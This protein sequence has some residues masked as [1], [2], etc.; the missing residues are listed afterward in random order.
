M[1]RPLHLSWSIQSSKLFSMKL[2]RLFFLFLLLTG[3]VSITGASTRNEFTLNNNWKFIKGNDVALL[4][5]Q[6]ELVNIPHTW[7][8]E[9]VMDDTPGYYRGMGLYK[10]E[11]RIPADWKE[12][13]VYLYFEG[14]AQVTEL[15]VN[16]ISAGKHIGSYTAFSFHLNKYLQFSA[17]G[18]QANEIIVKVDNSHNEDIPPL[19]G[20]FTLF[21]G[22]YR[23][24][25]I[26]VLPKVH[27]DADNYASSGVFI[28]TP[29]VT[30]DKAEVLIK[31]AF[32]N[33]TNKKLTVEVKHDILDTSGRLLTQLKQ[34]YKVAAGEKLAFETRKPDITG[35]SLWSID[36]PY[37]Y[38]VVSTI[39]DTKNEEVLDKISNPLGFR[40]FEF[41]PDKGFLL[42]GKHLKLIGASRHQDFKGLG[43]ALPNTLHVRDVELLKEMGGNFLRIAHYPQ[44]PEVLQACDRLGVL[45]TIETPIVNRITETED[46]T[47]N[48]TTMHLEM[49][50]QSYNHPS[51]IVWAYMNE[52]LLRPRFDKGSDRQEIYFK[53]ITRLARQLDELTRRED[54]YRYTMISNH[55]N[56]SLYKRLELTAIPQLVGWNVYAG[57]YSGTLDSFGDF[58]DQHHREL[59]DKPLLIS[60]YGAD[61]DNRLHSFT[62]ERF[63]KT[64]EYTQ[65]YHEKYLDA[66]IKRDFVSAGLIWNLAE[67]SSEER[68]ET[69]PHINAK[70]ILTQDRKT[71]NSYLFYQANLLQT[72]LLKFGDKDWTVRTGYATSAN[73][74]SCIQPVIVFSNLPETTLYHNGKALETKKTEQGVAKF[75]VPFIHGM[76]HLMVSHIKDGIVYC[77]NMEVRFKLLD[78]DLNSKSIPFKELNVSLGDKRFFFN[79]QDGRIWVPEQEYVAGSWGYIGGEI[80]KRRNS[81][82]QSYGSDKDIYGTD[83]D[84]VFATQRRNIKQF[85]FDVPPGIYRLTLHFAELNSDVKKAE[86]AYNL[87]SNKAEDDELSPR[88]FDVNINGKKVLDSLSNDIEMTPL[89]A[90]SFEQNI[91]TH[92]REGIVVDFVKNVGETILN[93]IQL[94]RVR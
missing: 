2:Q 81:T 72:P 78:R 68:G 20:D 46:F 47:R 42:N 84:P 13:E 87:D 53:N 22:I 65:L 61:A 69:T 92:D 45:A 62:P 34:Q 67:F 74:L 44:D 16:G 18:L 64:V 70:G 77:D 49:M 57:W 48:A 24:V 7:N 14:V 51:L 80:F 40:W 63:D 25:Y 19:S 91:E 89:K 55:R 75:D 28:S 71:K 36:N 17:S 26:Q 32:Q 93:G 37:L 1:F 3:F 8:V 66:M 76:N 58:L 52:V 35:Y 27:F 23:D 12:K 60:E 54:P 94:R 82:R 10:K 86:L 31:G 43:N 73:N 85:R 88:V 83:M 79:E 29:S 41:N 59:P 33:R 6:G 50:R 38:R 4:E 90:V 5:R 21:G 39:T 56:F 30:E 11:I 9:D 15:F